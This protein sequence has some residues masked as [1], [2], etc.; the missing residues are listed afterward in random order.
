MNFNYHSIKV[1][2][3]IIPITLLLLGVII[4]GGTASNFLQNNLLEQKREEGRRL[5]EQVERQISDNS[6]AVSTVESII[7]DRIYNV[8]Q[9]VIA[10]EGEISNQLLR[11]IAEQLNVVE[12]NWFSQDGEIIY[13]SISDYVGWSPGSDHVLSGFGE[14][15]QEQVMEDIRQDEVSGDYRKYGAVKSDSGDFVQVGINADEINQLTE[16]FGLQELVE[17]LAADQEVTYALF[18]NMDLEAEAHSDPSRIGIQLDDAGS[19]AAIEDQEFYASEYYYEAEGINVYDVLL[20]LIIDGQQI[21]AINVGYSMQSI[22]QLIF[23][24]WKII[25]LI[26][27]AIFV[28]LALILYRNARNIIVPLE[29]AVAQC[30]K[31][32]NKDFS[33]NLKTKWL[34]RQ[35]EIGTLIRA[36]D[37]IRVSIGDIIE[38][39]LEKAENLSAFSQELSASGEEVAAAAEQVG[40]S[41]Q[42]VASGAEEQ[43]AQVEE[44]TSNIEELILQIQDVKKNSD[45]MDEQADNVMSNINEGNTSIKKSVDKI[46]KVKDNANQVSNSINELGELSNKIGEIVDLINNI[47][48]QTNLLAL[49]AAI[50]AARAGEAGRGFSVVADEIRELAEESSSATDQISGLIKEIQNSVKDAVGEMDNAG[51]VVNESVSSIDS[52]GKSFEEINLAAEKLRELIDEI[53]NK[54]DI[55]DENSNKVDASIREIASVSQEAASN[56]EEVAAASEEQSASTEEIVVAAE[57]LSEMAAD[58]TE[59]VNQFKL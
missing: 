33:N 9:L 59:L 35:D 19:R 46:N 55:V 51:K 2:I 48:D 52:T 25:A 12:I 24:S 58:L 50:E 15:N 23:D 26:G 1:K 40:E 47:A 32:S 3:L 14:S 8:S 22:N 18:I 6:A 42:Q 56:S 30:E 49:N 36:L 41:I 34:E 29:G 43:S 31:M 4:I 44:T 54:A 16:A 20:P 28:V 53:S 17:E 7:E 10:N 21:G 38:D 27:L 11:E 45:E 37:N 57:N 5:T 39:I 13:S